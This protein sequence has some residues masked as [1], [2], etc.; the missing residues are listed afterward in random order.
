MGSKFWMIAS[1]AVAAAALLGA[2]AAHAAA[3]LNGSFE[4]VVDDWAADPSKFQTPG[5]FQHRDAGDMPDKQ[6]D[7]VHGFRLGV[8]QAG[9]GDTEILIRQTFNTRGGLFSGAAA[10][11]AEDDVA[12]NDYGFVRLIRGADVFTLFSADIQSVGPYGYT[13]W[14]PFTMLLAGGEWTLEAGV[15]NAVDGFNPSFLLV[16]D[17]RVAEVPEPATWALMIGGFALAGAALRR[18]RY[19]A[20]AP[21]KA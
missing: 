16:D 20:R 2:P 17:F 21:S 15:V 11:L 6:Y 13:E 12:Y 8:L 9:A 19:S 10:F 3:I 5:V 14:T 18:Q 4:A 7:P 1:A